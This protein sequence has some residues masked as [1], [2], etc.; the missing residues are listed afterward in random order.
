MHTR[1][2]T[3]KFFYFVLKFFFYE[4]T[5]YWDPLSKL[6][7]SLVNG[8]KSIAS[9][10]LLLFLFMVIFA[11]LGMQIFGGKFTFPDT[12]TP[13]ANFDTFI[14]AMLT[15]FQMLTGEDWNS[16]M[17]IGIKAYGGIGNIMCLLPIVYFTVKPFLS[18]RDLSQN[19]LCWPWAGQFSSTPPYGHRILTIP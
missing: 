7:N 17:Y 18:S 16:T 13:R 15:V 8:I 19:D 4:G 1:T 3:V 9:L 12:A 14:R 5:K 6:I 2:R 11:L 10:L